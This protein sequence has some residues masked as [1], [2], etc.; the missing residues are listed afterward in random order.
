MPLFY[1]ADAGIDNNMYS[2]YWADW[3]FECHGWGAFCSKVSPNVNVIAGIQVC[4]NI[5]ALHAQRWC[6]RAAA[7]ESDVY[8]S[9]AAAPVHR[10]AAPFHI[11]ALDLAPRARVGCS[12]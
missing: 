1:P 8:P 3:A 7:F 4:L 12:P 5:A 10:L 2:R 6:I 9:L 11:L